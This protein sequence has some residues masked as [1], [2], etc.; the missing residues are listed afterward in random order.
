MGGKKKDAKAKPLDKMTAKELREEALKIEGISGVHAMNKVE[1]L[2]EIKK[3][4]GIVDDAPKTGIVRDLKL[5]IREF[6]AKRE[7]ALEKSDTRIAQILRKRITR[8][9]KLARRAA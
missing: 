7:E 6:R 4:K 9:K 8:L 3:A 2:S 5:K 1:L